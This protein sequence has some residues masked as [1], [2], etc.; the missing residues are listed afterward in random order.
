MGVAADNDQLQL[1]A[2][3]P[4]EVEMILSA[5][6]AAGGGHDDRRQHPR[7]LYRAIAELRLFSDPAGT[8]PYTLYTRDVSARGIGFIT[9]HQ[10]PLGYGGIVRVPAPR[11]GNPM[12]I[13]GT[14]FRCRQLGNGYF[15]GAM[16]FNREQW[17]F[18]PPSPPPG[19]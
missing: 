10:L 3:W 7:M 14:L 6:E 9:P 5:L 19:A 8:A 16:Y 4:R 11:S 12:S 18:A 13:H 1:A 15:E 2:D 17:I